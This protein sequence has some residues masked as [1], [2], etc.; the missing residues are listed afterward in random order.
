MVRF[1]GDSVPPL[2]AGPQPPSATGRS[3]SNRIDS[4]TSPDGP[5][6]P[7]QHPRPPRVGGAIQLPSRTALT[8]ARSASVMAHP[9]AAALVRTCSGVVQPAITVDTTGLDAR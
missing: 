3:G 9:A 1:G 2:N 8:S 6:R 4:D 5:E 7:V